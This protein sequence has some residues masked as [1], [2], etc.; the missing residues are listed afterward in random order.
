MS[1]FSNDKDF[2]YELTEL[3]SLSDSNERQCSMHCVCEICNS[4]GGYIKFMDVLSTSMTPCILIQVA[5]FS[6]ACVVFALSV[7]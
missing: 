4:N 7:P 1:S 2:S 6:K 3:H 5:T